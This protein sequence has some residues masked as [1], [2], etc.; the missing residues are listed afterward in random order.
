MTIRFAD[1]YTG[2]VGPVTSAADLSADTMTG[3][4]AYVS[5]G[6]HGSLTTSVSFDPEEFVT[7]TRTYSDQESV[8]LWVTTPATMDGVG[9][10][11]SVA[12]WLDGAGN[13]TVRCGFNPNGRW[14]LYTVDGDHSITAGAG[15]AVALN[16]TYGLVFDL[17]LTGRFMSL[18]IHNATTDAEIDTIYSGYVPTAAPRGLRIGNRQPSDSAIKI[19]DVTEAD[20]ALIIGAPP[21]ATLGLIGSRI[22][23]PTS[24]TVQVVTKTGTDVDQVRLRVQLYSDH[25]L[26]TTTANLFPSLLGY[27]LHTITG[28]APNTQYEYRVDGYDDG[29]ATWALLS[30]PWTGAAYLGPFKTLV[31][32]DTSD[33]SFRFALE[34]CSHAQPQ[35]DAY[36]KIVAR[37]PLFTIG[38]G[39]KTYANRTDTATPPHFIAW[40]EAWATANGMADMNAK[41]PNAQQ[42][43]DHDGGEGGNTG[44]GEP[45]TIYA[46]EAIKIMLPMAEATT[47]SPNTLAQ[48]FRVGRHTFILP[49]FRSQFRTDAYA[50][51]RTCYGTAQLAALIAKIHEAGQRGDFIWWCTDAIMTSDRSTLLGSS[52]EKPDALPVY[53]SDYAA[54]CT[55]LG[56]Y[57]TAHAILSADYHALGLIYAHNDTAGPLVQYAGT[58]TKFG[59]MRNPGDYDE[60]YNPASGSRGNV[61][62]DIDV[63]QTGDTGT[64]IVHGWDAQNNIERITHTFYFD[65]SNPPPLPP[66]VPTQQT[67]TFDGVDVSNVVTQVE[68]VGVGSPTMRGE[69]SVVP[70]WDGRQWNGSKAYDENEITFSM[71]VRGANA[72]GT[73]PTDK[74]ELAQA[75]ANL[76]LLTRIFSGPNLIEIRKRFGDEYRIVFGQVVNRVDFSMLQGKLARFVVTFRCPLPFWRDE[77]PRRQV[78]PYDFGTVGNVWFTDF[79]GA[80]ARTQSAYIEAYGQLEEPKFTETTGRGSFRYVGSVQPSKRLIVDV[81]AGTVFKDE[82]DVP[83]NPPTDEI[84]LVEKF[85]PGPLITL[86]PRTKD[87]ADGAYGIRINVSAAPGVGAEIALTDYRWYVLHG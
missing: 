18:R 8:R 34:A 79:A 13:P 31:A 59:N 84:E 61:F 24:S 2:T 48:S 45:G 44:A 43:S 16:T 19:S 64:I 83:T 41:I 15:S 14:K 70:Y 3:A 32:A 71:W 20:S 55:A 35:R 58:I 85:D 21:P 9:Q 37:A 40:E 65:L 66:E 25:S 75:R 23:I 7:Y 63:A 67:F 62:F 39:D 72:D 47:L 54:V 36:D 69:N 29:T 38:G 56:L 76:D 53:E 77:T 28:L 46:L 1:T 81:A 27:T 26:V 74:I 68:K 50:A 11:W 51:S 49:D 12:E 22:G 87:E 30:N 33:V 86:N 80:T 42:R 52:P 73:M 82:P 4:P 57:P 78:V 17:D 5:G 6:G 60:V 10:D